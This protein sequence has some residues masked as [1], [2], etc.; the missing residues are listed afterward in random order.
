[1]EFFYSSSFAW[2]LF[3]ILVMVY[4]WSFIRRLYYGS[5]DHRNHRKD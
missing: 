3:V 2:I 5:G 4:F 1:M